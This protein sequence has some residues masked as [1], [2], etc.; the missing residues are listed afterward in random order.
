MQ[1]SRDYGIGNKWGDVLGPIC[2]WI[3]IIN[4]DHNG[5][6]DKGNGGCKI[7]FIFRCKVFGF[8]LH[9][10]RDDSK[11]SH[12]DTRTQ[13]HTHK[14]TDRKRYSQGPMRVENKRKE[15]DE[16]F[17][18]PE[19]NQMELRLTKG[20]KEKV[21]LKTEMEEKRMEIRSLWDWAWLAGGYRWHPL[22]G[23][24]VAVP[25]IVFCSSFTYEHLQKHWPIC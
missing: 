6:D 1:H 11:Y 14:Y 15:Q 25:F 2:S 20:R 19:L 3:N 10:L 13:T 22:T 23:T 4:R 18:W 5:S 7:D 9:C 24:L 8:D 16:V 21:R 17:K 12:R